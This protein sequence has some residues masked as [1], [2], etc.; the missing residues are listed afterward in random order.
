[1]KIFLKIINLLNEIKLLVASNEINHEIIEVLPNWDMNASQLW[2]FIF[3][4][5]W[6]QNIYLELTSFKAIKP[7]QK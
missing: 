1:L 7:S 2:C 6:I 5:T 4:F 3:I